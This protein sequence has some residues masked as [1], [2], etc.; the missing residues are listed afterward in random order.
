MGKND[1]SD[2][3]TVSIGTANCDNCVLKIESKE[4]K[5]LRLAI[6][7]TGGSALQIQSFRASALSRSDGFSH[8]LISDWHVEQHVSPMRPG[9]GHY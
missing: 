5:V 1:D 2:W 8:H 4:A 6:L 3:D 7:S 9:I